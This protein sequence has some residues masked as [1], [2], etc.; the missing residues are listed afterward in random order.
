MKTDKTLGLGIGHVDIAQ[1]T[2]D[3]TDRISSFFIS[4]LFINKKK[5]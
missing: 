3:W 5:K 2:G 1:G 4:S